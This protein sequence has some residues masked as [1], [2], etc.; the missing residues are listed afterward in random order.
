M[1]TDSIITQAMIESGIQTTLD[2]IHPLSADA[3]QSVSR[4]SSACG[5]RW[6]A[7][8]TSENDADRLVAESDGLLAL[9]NPG[10]LY[11]PHAH[12]IVRVDGHA[13]L[14]MAYLEPARSASDEDW[15]RFGEALARHHTDD[16]GHFYGW[17]TDNYIGA[18]PQPNTRCEDWVEFN[19]EYRLGYQLRYASDNERLSTTEAARVRAVIDHLDRYIPHRPH[20]SLIHGDLWSGNVLPTIIHDQTQIAIIDPAVYIGDGWADIAMLNAFGSPPHSFHK[21]Y[22]RLQPDHDNL[23][24]RVLV[25][26][27]YHMLNHLNLFGSSYLGSVMRI[28][29]ALRC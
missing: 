3:H 25:Y 17:D 27:L 12:P 4:V 13:V 7:K 15:A 8:I 28:V 29:K 1:R 24:E 21:E 2:S 19:A 6:V 22:T 26:Q 20:P 16:H 5:Q 23:D 9:R 10:H 18:T 11:L 14:I